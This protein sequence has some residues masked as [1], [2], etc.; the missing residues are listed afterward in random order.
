MK[1]MAI[2]IAAGGGMVAIHVMLARYP[3][4]LPNWAICLLFLGVSLVSAS[5]LS[6][7]TIRDLVVRIVGV[8]VVIFIAHTLVSSSYQIWIVQVAPLLII[9][10]LG[11]WFGIGQD[12]VLPFDALA[13]PSEPSEP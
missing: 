1:Q 10:P 8:A 4:D 2:P 11:L 3:V 7:R 6:V 12:K 13:E 5:L 9:L